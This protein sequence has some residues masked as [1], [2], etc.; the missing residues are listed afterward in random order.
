MTVAS[1]IA[2]CGKIAAV[3]D[4][5]RKTVDSATG[6]VISIRKFIDSFGNVSTQIYYKYDSDGDGKA[7]SEQVIYDVD[8]YIPD[9][10]EP[11]QLVDKDGEIGIGYPKLRAI[12]SSEV[13]PAL[14]SADSEN[15]IDYYSS[16]GDGYRISLQ[17]DGYLDDVVYPLPFDFTGDGINDFQ[18]VVDDNN[19]GLPDYCPSAPFYPIGS[20]GY[21]EIV[22]KYSDNV[23][24]LTKSFHNYTVSEALL[25]I[26][27]C[28]S[29]VA[30]FSKIF[31]RRSI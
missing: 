2:L 5:V 10:S 30:I 3:I 7:D 26:I 21:Q 9:L 27:A 15:D 14:P 11:Y 19:N 28:G 17:D 23:P 31:K 22:E 25:F 24:A 1:V 4:A 6:L 13:L 18:I 16:D 20:E 8:Y 29:L 12:D